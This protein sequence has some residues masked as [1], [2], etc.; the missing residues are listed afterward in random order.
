M[1]D[2]TIPIGSEPEYTS[3][4]YDYIPDGSGQFSNKV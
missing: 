1:E 2:E 3:E 4:H